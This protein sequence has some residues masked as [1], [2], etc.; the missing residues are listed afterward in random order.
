[1]GIG[2]TGSASA[3]H[4]PNDGRRIEEADFGCICISDGLRL[5]VEGLV[6]FREF[7]GK[8]GRLKV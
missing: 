4:V 3:R 8:V 6:P 1:M 7:A 5:G 2:L